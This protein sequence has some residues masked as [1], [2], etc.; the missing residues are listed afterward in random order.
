[1]KAKAVSRQHGDK[2]LTA[3]LFDGG[4][5]AAVILFTICALRRH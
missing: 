5:M 3:L 2:D 4:L 1:M